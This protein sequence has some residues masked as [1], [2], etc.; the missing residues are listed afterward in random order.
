MQ[1]YNPSWFHKNRVYP[2]QSWGFLFMNS[3]LLESV[4]ESKEE[5]LKYGHMT[6]GRYFPSLTLK[7][8]TE[9]RSTYKEPCTT[10]RVYLDCNRGLSSFLQANQLINKTSSY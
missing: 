10:S 9:A 4:L 3:Q 6:D 5:A 1:L 8:L 7:K 2:S